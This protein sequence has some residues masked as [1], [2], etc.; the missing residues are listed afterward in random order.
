[1]KKQKI[2]KKFLERGYQLDPRSLDFF[3][4]NPDKIEIFLEKINQTK[5]KPSVITLDFINSLFEKLPKKTEIEI[6]RAFEQKKKTSVG[7]LTNFFVDRYEK[8]RKMFSGRSDL[9]NLISINKIT[10]RTKK[11]SL[12]GLVKEK[13]GKNLVLEDLTGEINVL[14]KKDKKIVLDEVVGVVCEQD[15]VVRV[16]NVLFPDVPLKREINK[17]KKETYCLFIS[18]IHMD[19]K[20]FQKPN[21]KKFLDW[22]NEKKFEK[23]YIFVLG[24]VSSNKEDIV[25][26]FDSLPEEVFKIYLKGED[27]P[28]LK[29]GDLQLSELVLIRIEKNVVSLLFHGG[30]LEKYSSLWKDPPEEI[31]LNL[32][33]KRHIDPIFEKK[34]YEHDPF[35]LDIIPD[36]V[37]FGHLHSPGYLNYKGTTIL[38]TGS[39]ITKPIFWLINLKT[40]ET[41]KLDF[42]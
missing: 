15:D 8:I 40:R 23:L 3:H 17:T 39:F 24:H 12:I 32:L 6:L 36:I 21:Y 16:K 18:D 30:L 10:P 22:L 34:F 41:I 20:N 35:V 37:A 5:A 14:L 42:S 4:K 13:T 31:M 33:K 7:D 2:I 19:D 11:F 28:D 27:D 29:V 25:N 26:F 38:S 9:L 1:M